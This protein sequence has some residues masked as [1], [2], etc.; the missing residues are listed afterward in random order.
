MTGIINPV[1]ADAT[2]VADGVLA[3][4]HPFAVAKDLIDAPTMRT[5][6]NACMYSVGDVDGFAEAG[7]IAG[8][9]AARLGIL[10]A[11]LAAAIHMAKRVSK[12]KS[13]L[14]RVY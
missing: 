5:I 11:S 13:M 8:D 10:A 6:L 4:S 9:F 14:A 12:S 3:A 7:F 2:I 1:T